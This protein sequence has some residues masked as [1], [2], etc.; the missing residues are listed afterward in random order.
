MT[1]QQRLLQRDLDGV[2]SRNESAAV[3]GLAASDSVLVQTQADLQRLDVDLKT[4]AP[5]VAVQ[6]E[7]RFRAQ[8]MAALPA[9]LPERQLQVRP[10]DV[11]YAMCAVALVVIGFGTLAT[12]SRTILE[13]T[14][15]LVW[16]VGISL[17]TGLALVVAPGFLRSCESGILGRVLGRPV[18]I[19]A[20]DALT[21]RAVGLS[22]VV[23][24]LW[25]TW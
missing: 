1:P 15:L 20:A 22:L 18:A 4:L 5:P 16:L 8:I 17:V 10:I 19:G 21:Y 13:Q 9:G 25:L 24:G 12:A 6:D 11:I 2:L 7:A 23:G 14:T 3:A